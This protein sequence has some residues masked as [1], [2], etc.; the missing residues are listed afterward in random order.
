MRDS[1]RVGGGGSLYYTTAGWAG[2]IDYRSVADISLGVRYVEKEPFAK[3]KNYLVRVNVA[4]AVVMIVI[5]GGCSLTLPFRE[6][7]GGAIHIGGDVRRGVEVIE[8]AKEGVDRDRECAFRIGSENEWRTAIFVLVVVVIS[9][10]V[11][12]NPV[13]SS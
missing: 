2:S 5:I 8:V 9:G 6:D 1:G 11:M 4:Q 3:G 10:G 13:P 12:G 7:N